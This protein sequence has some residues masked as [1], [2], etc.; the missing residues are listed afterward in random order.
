MPAIFMVTILTISALY[1]PQPLLPV[2]VDSFDVSSTR[3]AALTTVSFVPLALAPLFYGPFLERFH[4]LRLL[5]WGVLL[6]ALSEG[7]FF[8]APEFSQ[9]LLLRL[10][11]GLLIPALLIAAMTYLST[12]SIAGQVPRVMA[13]YIA[14]TI[15]GGLLGRVCSGFLA[16][17]WGWRSSFLVLGFSLLAA[18]LLLLPLEADAPKKETETERSWQLL[19]QV[20]GRRLFRRVYLMVF[21]FFFAFAAIMNFIPF[22]LYEISGA[23]DEW[24]V[25][26]IYCGYLMGVVSALSAVRVKERLGSERRV[27]MLGLSAY[28]AVLLVMWLPQ[29]P[30][31]F[32]AMFLF[33]GAMFLVHATATGWLNRLSDQH[34]GTV[35]GLYVASYYGGGMAGSFVPG[36]VYQ[37]WGWGAFIL[38]LAGVVSAALF[39]SLGLADS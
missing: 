17:L 39:L 13:T 19:P 34:K 15:V 37:A 3:A 9:L 14:A 38:L 30:V 20:L 28:L 36:F 22:R 10:C 26:L 18:Y 11:Q 31:L 4:P 29:V 16:S 35:N 6:L 12:T 1:A 5:R 33:C 24:R 23:A 7:L 25:G 32:V 2:I 27:V 8:L 21:C